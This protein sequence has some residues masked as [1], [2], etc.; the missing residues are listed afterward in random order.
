M[1]RNLRGGHRAIAVKSRTQGAN[2]RALY[3]LTDERSELLGRLTSTV[4]IGIQT[5]AI[6]EAVRDAIRFDC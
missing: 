5:A 3:A 2:N 6:V 1:V 4:A